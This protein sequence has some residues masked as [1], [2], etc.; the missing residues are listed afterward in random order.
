ML[1]KNGHTILFLFAL[2]CTHAVYA[3]FEDIKPE[4]STDYIN[5]EQPKHTFNIKSNPFSVIS[6]DIPVFSAEY[7]L[8]A[9]YIPNRKTSISFGLS[10]LGLGPLIRAIASLDSTFQSNGNSPTD[11]KFRGVRVQTGYRLYLNS[12]LTK[13]ATS[14]TEIPPEGVFVYGLFSYSRAKFFD[15]KFP[16]YYADFILLSATLNVGYQFLLTDQITFELYFG[17]GYK[18]N[19]IFEVSPTNRRRINEDWIKNNFIY[20]NNTK[21]N[22][23]FNFGV[24]F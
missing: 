20:G 23:G 5:Y 9:E 2:L 18:N 19:Q 16:Q 22:F 14:K 8:I 6:G 13:T 17:G 15:R 4:N 1:K 7:R 11:L 12:L 24:A 3:Q 21:I 10:Y